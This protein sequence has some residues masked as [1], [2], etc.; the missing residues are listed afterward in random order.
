[1]GEVGR[2]EQIPS[3]KQKLEPE[4]I[5]VAANPPNQLCKY[6]AFTREKGALI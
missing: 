3:I 4:K 6:S 5:H 1:M 2:T